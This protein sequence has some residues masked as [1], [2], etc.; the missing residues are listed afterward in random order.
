[1]NMSRRAALVASAAALK[2]VGQNQRGPTKQVQPGATFG[3]CGP[4][5]TQ[6]KDRSKILTP[7]F[8]EIG[9]YRDLVKEVLGAP[10]LKTLDG[11][12]AAENPNGLVN[13]I[14]L[15]IQIARAL[16]SQAGADAAVRGMWNAFINPK[17]F[18]TVTIFDPGARKNVAFPIYPSQNSKATVPH[19]TP[20]GIRL[21]D[22]RA[23]IPTSPGLRVGVEGEP[24]PPAAYYMSAEDTEALERLGR[25]GKHAA[26]V[27]F[28]SAK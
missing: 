21:S 12:S 4:V 15:H 3:L 20:S 11:L 1:M 26:E 19:E 7:V 28:S 9:V 6:P 27:R 25:S 16:L 2:A 13:M 14:G 5:P 18:G 8:G 23:I 10:A 24:T 22:G 17:P